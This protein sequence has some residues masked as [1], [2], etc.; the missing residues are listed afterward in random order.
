MEG[1]RYERG[2]CPECFM[3]SRA[4]LTFHLMDGLCNLAWTN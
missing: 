1:S 2:D 3:I 4:I